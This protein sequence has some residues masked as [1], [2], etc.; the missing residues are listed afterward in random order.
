MVPVEDTGGDKSTQ[1]NPSNPCNLNV[2]VA[3]FDN[4]QVDKS[5][6]TPEIGK[7]L[8]GVILNK[9]RPAQFKEGLNAE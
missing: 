9:S 8:V 1:T 5:S 3:T 2:L 4:A 6:S 7:V